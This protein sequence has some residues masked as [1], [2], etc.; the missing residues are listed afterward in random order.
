MFTLCSAL[1]G[2]I[3]AGC[4]GIAH[5][6]I[7]YSISPEYYTK[8]KFYQFGYVESDAPNRL[9]VFRIG[10]LAS[11]WVGLVTGW[12]IGRA[13]YRQ[14]SLAVSIKR[15]LCSIFTLV[16]SATIVATCFGTYFHLFGQKTNHDLQSYFGLESYEL[17]PFLLVGNIH[18]GSYLG[19][20]IALIGIISVLVWQNRQSTKPHIST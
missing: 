5:D 7:T 1:L 17:E 14:T 8:F 15:G 13:S 10:V 2:A 16:L 11:W 9:L 18:N 19:A 12:L 4:Y 20:I 6:Q 3:V